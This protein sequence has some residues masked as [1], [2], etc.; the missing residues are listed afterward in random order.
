MSERVKVLF[1]HSQNGFGADSAIHAHLMRYLDRSRFTVHV[2]CSAGD[3][4]SPSAAYAKFQEIPDIRLRAVHFAPGFHH[5]SR[6]A[7]LRELRN[8]TT[9]PLDFA[10]LRAYI[11]RERIQIIHGT[12]R[13]RDAVYAVALSKLT[14]AKSIVHIHV[15]W[16]NGYSAAAKWGVRHADAV[17][18]ISRFVTR[19]IV[20]TG[21]PRERV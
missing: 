12:D 20:K 9:F 21:T 8:A 4:A 5:R 15:A 3:G 1:I 10:R 19:T 7:I 6:E 18:S 17:F 14:R 2:A 13:P 16:S 11:L